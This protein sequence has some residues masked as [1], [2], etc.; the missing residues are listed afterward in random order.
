MAG[1]IGGGVNAAVCGGALQVVVTIEFRL[2]AVPVIP[3]LVTVGTRC[4]A[5]EGIAAR[6]ARVVAI[7]LQGEQDVLQ[8][9][10]CLWDTRE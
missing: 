4:V 7:R 8:D 3:L 1:A 2:C 6:V 9:G 10:L 5:G